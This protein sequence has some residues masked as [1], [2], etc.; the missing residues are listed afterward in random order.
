M[1]GFRNETASSFSVRVLMGFE[2]EF[3]L[4]FLACL[5]DVGIVIGVVYD[6]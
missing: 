5:L 1:R 2:L 4:T 3:I 6:T